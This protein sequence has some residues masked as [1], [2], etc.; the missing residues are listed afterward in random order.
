M[1]EPKSGRRGGKRQRRRACGA[2]SS[3]GV[4]RA[5][6]GVVLVGL[7]RLERPGHQRRSSPFANKSH[8][9]RRINA[10]AVRLKRCVNR[11][12]CWNTRGRIADLNV[13]ERRKQAA[14]EWSACR[15]AALA[16]WQQRSAAWKVFDSDW[17]A[18]VGNREKQA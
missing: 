8:A 1:A 9:S 11:K 7:N 17:V 18:N 6:P 4:L 12:I 2:F 10:G 16:E 14:F 13:R 5:G 15:N 3:T